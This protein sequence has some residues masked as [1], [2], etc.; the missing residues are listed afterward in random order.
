MG[1]PLCEEGRVRTLQALGNAAALINSGACASRTV[2]DDRSLTSSSQLVEGR[3][4]TVN[5]NNKFK[6][7]NN[8]AR[9]GGQ[10]AE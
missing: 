8:G 9:G 7:P 10:P 5:A 3:W 6:G 4:Y 2:A 1:A